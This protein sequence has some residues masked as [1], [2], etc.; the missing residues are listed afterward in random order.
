M[1][2]LIHTVSFDSSVKRKMTARRRQKQ[3]GGFTKTEEILSQSRD[4]GGIFKTYSSHIYHSS[5]FV[6]HAVA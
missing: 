1:K 6:G 4:G 5:G 3:K 2:L